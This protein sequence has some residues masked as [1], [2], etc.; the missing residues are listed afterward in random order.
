MKKILFLLMLVL[1]LAI[2]LPAPAE[3][4][5]YTGMVTKKMTM[6]ERKSTSARKLG[7]VEEGE[8][9]SIID[10]G[11]QWT[12]IEKD[13]MTGYVLTKNVTDLALAEGYNDAADAEYIGV[14]T[15]ELTIR[16]KQ[17]KSALK[18]QTLAEGETV[19]ILELGKQWHK[20]IKNGVQGYVLAD[21]ITGLQGAHE[22]IEVPEQ[23]VT[24]PA[25]EAVYSAMADVNLSIRRDKDEN[26]RLM[27][28][29]YKNE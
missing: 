5:L 23:F 28:T 11:E 2:S 14:A 8:F 26:S 20:V 16:E 24:A 18:M 27:G 19:Y 1:V 6:R 12:K 25:F 13:G 10:Y 3:E 15:K 4:V 17:S 9:I 7:S 21:P 22:G 29:V